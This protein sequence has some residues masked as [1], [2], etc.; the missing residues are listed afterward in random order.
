MPTHEEFEKVY[1]IAVGI[2]IRK[3]WA[4]VY[5]TSKSSY[6]ITDLPLFG[7]KKVYTY[8]VINSPFHDE[9]NGVNLKSVRLL[10]I[11]CI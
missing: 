1:F 4:F 7:V 10:F 8:T 2:R 5:V 6:V 3:L 11:I 9:H